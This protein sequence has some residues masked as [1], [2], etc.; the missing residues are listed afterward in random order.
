MDVYESVRLID[1]TL[2]GRVVLMTGGA[3][4]HRAGEFLASVDS[5]VLQKPFESNE[6]HALVHTIEQRHARVEAAVVTAGI[7]TRGQSPH[8]TES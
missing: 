2:L 8:E 5:P 1:S 3:F 4:T 7:I 6:L